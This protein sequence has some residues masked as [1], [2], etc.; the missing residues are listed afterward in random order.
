MLMNVQCAAVVFLTCI[1][2]ASTVMSQTP[3]HGAVEGNVYLDSRYGMRYTFPAGLKVQTVLNGMPVG[4]GEKQGSSEFLFD[5]MEDPTGRVRSGVFITSDPRGSLGAKDASEFLQGI[6]KLGMGAKGPVDVREI[7]LAGRKFYRSDV[8]VG[9]PVHSYGA[10]I[11]TSCNG[12]F[13]VFY[14]S[15]ASPERV[16]QLVHSMNTL[17]LECSERP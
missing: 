3:T 4:T 7:L 8:G 10:Q 17:Q 1:F 15:G 6:A 14:F 13:V 9:L 2:S 12:H 5:A 16:E 11:A